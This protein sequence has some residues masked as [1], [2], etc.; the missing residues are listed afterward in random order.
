LHLVV[1]ISVSERRDRFTP[2]LRAIGGLEVRLEAHAA[3]L[4]RLKPL[5]TITTA[6]S[7]LETN[8]E[9]LL[10]RS[11]AALAHLERE[12]AALDRGHVA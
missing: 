7:K 11:E 5:V 8:L 4:L 10:S 2:L 9:L 12:R 3:I 6:V 1:I